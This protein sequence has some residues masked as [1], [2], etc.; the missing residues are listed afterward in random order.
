MNKQDAKRKFNI[1]VRFT[2]KGISSTSK[3]ELNSVGYKY[4]PKCSDIKKLHK[5]SKSTRSGK[6]TYQNYCKGC[7]SSYK[8]ELGF[9]TKKYQSRTRYDR[10]QKKKDYM[11]RYDLVN[12]KAKSEYRKKFRKENRERLAPLEIYRANKRRAMKCNA[13][14]SWSQEDKIKVL[15]EKAKWLESLT[16]KKYHVDHI[17]PLQGKNVCGL[18]VWE[19]LQ[20]LEMKLNIRKSNKF[21]GEL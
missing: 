17:I 15:Y 4:C 12:K 10:S 6:S 5:F 1:D 9:T 11:K 21:Q 20:I 7:N 13:T 8:K 16:G 19:N 3:K 14:P 2:K 18:H